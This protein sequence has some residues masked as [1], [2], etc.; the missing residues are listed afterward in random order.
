MASATVAFPVLWVG[1]AG[2]GKLKAARAA[3]C[4]SAGLDLIPG[5][6]QEPRLQSLEI[7]DYNARYWEFPTHMEID[8]MDLSMMD[9][10]ILPE[11]L[12]Q[13]LS[14]RD[15]TGGRRKIMI[16]RRIHALSPAAAARMRAV[17]EELVWQPGAPAMIWCTARVTNSVV[18][19]LADGFVYRRVAATERLDRLSL[20]SLVSG[21]GLGPALA[22]IPTIQT[23]IS[24]MMRQMAFARSEGPACLAVAGWIRGRVYDL[25]GLMITG[26]ELVSSLTW[27]TL[28]M[29]AN[30][31][32]T[33]AQTK[34]CLDVLARARWFPSYRTPL[35]LEMIV[36]AVYNA[37][38]STCTQGG[39]GT[40][41]SKD[42]IVLE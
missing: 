10:Q 26:S 14:T 3:I 33:D 27:S 13:L 8:I 17:M 31:T 22:S 1:P 42:E 30:R 2:A 34:A 24:E 35:M 20:P 28:R 11:L 15:V 18:A 37:L 5:P 7:G 9:K 25:L 16:V 29:G 4:E 40:T 6:G 12:T 41:D 36:T 32:L 21:P 19:T 38:D 39:K 23:Y